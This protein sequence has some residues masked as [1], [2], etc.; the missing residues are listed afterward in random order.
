ME[1]LLNNILLLP[2]NNL[3]NKWTN[4]TRLFMFCVTCSLEITY[5]EDMPNNQMDQI[6]HF[7]NVI[8]FLLE[9]PI[10]WLIDSC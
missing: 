8:I 10:T 3:L 6:Y 5:I 4:N 7:A 9:Q 2:K 1:L